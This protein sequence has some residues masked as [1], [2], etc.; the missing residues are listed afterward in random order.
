MCSLWSHSIAPYDHTLLSLVVLLLVI[1]LYYSLWSCSLWSYFLWS[2]STAPCG[3]SLYG[4]VLL[5]F[6]VLL[7]MVMFCCS[8]SSHSITPYGQV[9]LLLV[10][11]FYY[12]LWLHFT[13]PCGYILLLV[14]A[15]CYSL[16]SHLLLVDMLYSYLFVSTPCGCVLLFLVV[17]SRVLLLWQ[18]HWLW[19]ENHFPN[20]GSTNNGVLCFYFLFAFNVNITF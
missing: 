5:L 4:H 17:P 10:V 9:L 16:W 20:G 15:L 19:R 18:D 11:K 7:L 3:P 14:V 6:V 8:L 12:S 2:H 1:A 13:T